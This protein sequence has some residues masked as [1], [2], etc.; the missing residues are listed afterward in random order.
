M[1]QKPR[2]GDPRLETLLDERDH[3]IIKI[4]LAADDVARA[5]ADEI[6]AMHKRVAQIETIIAQKWSSS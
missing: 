3:L 2:P 1:Q 4:S 5:S 6:E